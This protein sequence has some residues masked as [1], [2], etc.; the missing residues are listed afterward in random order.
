MLVSASACQSQPKAE[1]DV[2][3]GGGDVERRSWVLDAD[4]SNLTLGENE[5]V[6][7]WLADGA[8]SMQNVCN[9]VGG[10]YELDGDQ[11]VVAEVMSTSA[12]CGS[13]DTSDAVE[14]AIRGRSTLVVDGDS[15]TLRGDAG[16]SVL[17][18]RE[19]PSDPS[20]TQTR[21]TGS[22]RVVPPGGGDPVDSILTYT[23]DGRFDVVAGCTRL[24]GQ[25]VV[26]AGR[27]AYPGAQR[28]ELLTE[29]ESAPTDERLVQEA[30][31]SA[32]LRAIGEDLELLDARGEP[33]AVLA[34][35]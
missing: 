3:A 25:W 27:I 7:L 31:D 30:I 16:N 15:M 5:A 12:G 4:A 10:D 28:G 23:A 18:F 11:L 33:V 35:A 22:W 29:C 2:S 1:P 20:V 9:V 32:H 24:G 6:T 17:R 13:R 19:I 14:A 8:L 21:L 34:P 26:E